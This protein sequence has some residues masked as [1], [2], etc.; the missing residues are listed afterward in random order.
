MMKQVSNVKVALLSTVLSAVVLSA[1]GAAATPTQSPAP[2]TATQV[3]SSGAAKVF[4][5]VQETSKASY[6]VDEVF[7]NQNNKLNTAIGLTGVVNGD[8][9]V[10][11][12]NPVNS[13]VSAITID[14]SKLKSDS[15]KRDDAIRNRW[16]E[17]TKFPTVKFTPTKI[18][19]L[20]P[21]YA[22]G[23][24]LTFKVTGDMTVRDSTKPV[25]F[26]VT[27]KID[28]DKLTGTATSAIKMSNFNF[29]PPDVAGILKANDDA[30]LK[31]EFVATP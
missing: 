18:E 14:I 8:I 5:I 27:A 30:K 25:I 4:H 1:C 12:A 6:E 13:K 3:S 22:A 7:L 11:T 24:E 9:T 10:D 20:P 23:Q 28:G 29:S 15:G 21:T 26:D 19:G 16:L 2:T 31:L 17:S